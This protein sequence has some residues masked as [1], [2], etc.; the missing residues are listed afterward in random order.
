MITEAGFFKRLSIRRPS[1][2]GRGMA[3]LADKGAVYL[4]LLVGLA[5]YLGPLLWLVTSSLSPYGAKVFS[6]PPQLIPERL[7]LRNFWEATEIFPF[8][9]YLLNTVVVAGGTVA[10]QLTMCSLAAYPLSRM[11]FRGRT[12]AFYAILATMIVPF[13]SIMIPLFV[14]CTRLGLMNSYTG[15]ILPFGV[16]AFGVFLL[17]Q[18]FSGIPGELVDAARVDGCSEWGIFSRIALPLIKPAL[19]TLAI[20]AFTAQWNEFLWPLILLTDTNL[21]TLQIGVM[22]ATAPY[23]A[24]WQHLAAVCV[25]TMVPVV[26]FYFAL[27]RHFTAGAMA[28]A[29][30]G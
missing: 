6:F 25:L 12:I 14:V 4:L 28:G 23:G 20:F 30:K 13:H 26:V 15:L 2:H 24:D 9:R 8:W 1:V 29:L 7:T 22:A 3:R 27:Q 10:L 18:A 11:Y 17:R 21:Y 16:D 5:V 19:A